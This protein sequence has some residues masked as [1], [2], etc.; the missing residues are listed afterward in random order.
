MSGKERAK[1]RK[2]DP[3][4]DTD[5]ERPPSPETVQAEREPQGAVGLRPPEG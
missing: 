4:F 2:L 1:L 5:Q 3:T